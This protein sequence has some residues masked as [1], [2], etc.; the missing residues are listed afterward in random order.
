MTPLKSLKVL[1]HEAQLADVTQER[2]MQLMA[3]QGGELEQVALFTLAIQAN[4][5]QTTPPLLCCTIG[6]GWYAS[7]IQSMAFSNGKPLVD[8]LERISDAFWHLAVNGFK[9]ISFAHWLISPDAVINKATSDATLTLSQFTQGLGIPMIEGG[10]II[11]SELDAEPFV[12]STVVGVRK[13]AECKRAPEVGQKVFMFGDYTLPEFYSKEAG[14]LSR[15][16]QFNSGIAPAG[17]GIF[18]KQID[19]A[20]G[21]LFR[22]DL[23]EDVEPLTTLG[24]LNASISLAKRWQLGLNIDL[25]TVLIGT[26]NI[27]NAEILVSETLNRLIAVCP[28]GKETIFEA[29]LEKWDIPYTCI[30]EIVSEDVVCVKGLMAESLEVPI[31]LYKEFVIE[32]P[33]ADRLPI[34]TFEKHELIE[35]SEEVELRKAIE[36]VLSSTSFSPKL[37]F[38]EQFD[39]SLQGGPNLSNP[40]DAGIT[41]LRTLKRNLAVA[42]VLN[43]RLSRID[44]ERTLVLNFA[45]ATRKVICSGAI[46]LQATLV[47][48]VFG[49][50]ESQMGTVERLQ[51][52]FIEVCARWGV[53]ASSQRA[54]IK[55]CFGEIE[56]VLPS[57]AVLGIVDG[58]APL[59][60]TFIEKGDM[61]YLLGDPALSLNGSELE[62]SLGLEQKNELPYFDIAKE[63][64]L[65]KAIYKL[66]QLGI[67][68]SAH[69]VGRGGIF[70]SLV[71]CG[72]ANG[73]GFD[74]TS[75]SEISPNAFLFGE[76]PGMAVV[77]VAPARE[78][79]FI[80]F[81]VAQKQNFRTLG[82]VTKAEVRIDDIS[83]GFIFDL[84]K[85]FV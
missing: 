22:A 16:F 26:S 30:G 71:D 11:S 15:A 57:I 3:E 63:F 4:M 40:S 56:K 59:T 2:L 60:R 1:L 14:I 61:I 5:E 83:Y 80:D 23:I 79:Q 82:H 10:V 27:S 58:P 52:L 12:C 8:G 42:Q 85:L 48:A 65:Q 25:S 19:F 53:V 20:L 38:K 66:F 17:K 73:L 21:D 55:D 39:S 34:P 41:I 64:H 49:C 37:W 32:K 33:S 68:S 81:M 74:I 6:D 75:D 28:T 13:G 84:R 7:I 36:L 18:A 31:G 47:P 69:S 76:A 29:V 78:V 45:E 54:F 72:H 44:Q 43:P 50:T 9:P 67:L 70:T 51:Q 24:L 35:D 77:T 62:K 46:P